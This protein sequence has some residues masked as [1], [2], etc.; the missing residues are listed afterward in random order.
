MKVAAA[1]I[2]WCDH[3]RTNSASWSS[4]QTVTVPARFEGYPYEITDSGWS[5]VVEVVEHTPDRC[6]AIA[7][8]RFLAED[9][10]Q[11]YIRP[12]AHFTL[13]DGP[14][15]IADGEIIGEPAQEAWRPA[16]A[17]S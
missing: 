17:D 11:E 16:F 5:L 12:G 3:L 13:Y 10:P 9:A 6:S 15:K 7:N 8:V 4:G 2:R 1:R 14:T